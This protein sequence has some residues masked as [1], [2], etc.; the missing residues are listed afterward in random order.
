MEE[1]LSHNRTIELVSKKPKVLVI[2]T[3]GTFGFQMSNP[4]HT[5]KVYFSK[6]YLLTELKCGSYPTL[7][8]N[9]DFGENL[10]END[11]VMYWIYEIDPLLDSANMDMSHWNLICN[12]IK[13][14]YTCFD[15][16]VIL[17]GTNTMT[18][19]ASALSFMIKNLTKPIV[20]TGSIIPFSMDDSDALGNLEGALMIAATKVDFLQLSQ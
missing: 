19:S 4:G 12:L 9:F 6:N 15:G 3:G 13:Q 10:L 5:D 8:Y 20:L 17:H 11:F 7:N 16:F 18:Y 14:A 1:F 2:N